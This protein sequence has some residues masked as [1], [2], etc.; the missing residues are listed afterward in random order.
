MSLPVDATLP[1]PLSL[2]PILVP[3]L[4]VMVFVALSNTP[5]LFIIPLIS[6]ADI[7]VPTNEAEA[8]PKAARAE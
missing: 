2:S 8:P 6:S 1:P 7:E 4:V 5:P 3:P